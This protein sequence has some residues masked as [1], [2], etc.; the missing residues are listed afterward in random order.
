NNDK[1]FFDQVIIRGDNAPGVAPPAPAA[2][3]VQNTLAMQ[4]FAQQTMQTVKIYPNPA[5]ALLHI[6]LQGQPFDQVQVFSAT[7]ELLYN[8]DTES[9]AMT[10]DIGD[11]AKGLYFIRFV[12]NGL[13]TTQRFVKQ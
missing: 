10:I 8:W 4:Q 5:T 6:D 2:P 1:F 11:Y 3:Q 12:S 7:G 9:E 13:A